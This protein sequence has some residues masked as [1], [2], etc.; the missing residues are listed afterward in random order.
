MTCPCQKKG[1]RG[2]GAPSYLHEAEGAADE[3]DAAKLL[4]DALKLSRRGDCYEAVRHLEYAYELMGA[5]GAHLGSRRTRL[6]PTKA[7]AELRRQWRLRRA[8]QKTEL[9]IQ[10]S[11]VR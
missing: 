8:F 9:I 3:H 10:A 2:L 1:R 7:R 5:A 6:S 4:G 11:C